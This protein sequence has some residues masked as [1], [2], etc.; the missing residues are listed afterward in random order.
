M[1]IPIS[2][3]SSHANPYPS[4]AA[5]RQQ[6]GFIWDSATSCWLVSQAAVVE[7]VLHSPACGVRPAKEAIPSA[8]QGS[9]A[10]AIFGELVRMNEGCGHQAPKAALTQSLTSLC[11]R[12]ITAIMAAENLFCLSAPRDSAALRPLHNRSERPKFES[13]SAPVLEHSEHRR[14]KVRSRSSLCRGLTLNEWLFALPVRTVAMSLGFDADQSQQLASEIRSFIACLSASS[15]KAQ[16]HEA[17]AAAM[18]LRQTIE[19]LIARDCTDPSSFVFKLQTAARLHGWHAQSAI[20]A[21]MLGLLSQTYEATAAF[22]GNTIVQL[23]RQTVWRQQLRQELSTEAPDAASTLNAFIAEVARFD[24]SIHN[25][26]RYVLQ[27]CCI[28]GQE[29]RAGDAIIVLLAAANRDET[30]YADAE[31]FN[32][33]RT[34]SAQF[35]YS[36]GRHACPGQQIAFTIVQ[37]AA[38]YLLKQW[39]EPQWLALCWEYRP[40]FNARIPCFSFTNQEKKHDPRFL[41]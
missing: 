30:R 31:M 33:R 9:A 10:G 18:R 7:A 24:P 12:E 41:S 14:L 35:G 40:S 27:D 16:L 37:Q 8:I 39:S 2:Q 21:N 6:A 32:P 19:H 5:Y 3:L 20:I 11:P 22:L 34:P 25:T 26:R 15:D 28:A 29:L 13:R 4:Y 36:A 23:Q 17:S 1:S 38:A